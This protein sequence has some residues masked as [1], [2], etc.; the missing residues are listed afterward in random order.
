MI[1]FPNR[2][3]GIIPL[4]THLHTVAT[5][6]SNSLATCFVV[7]YLFVIV[8]LSAIYTRSEFDASGAAC[9]AAALRSLA[10]VGTDYVSTSETVSI[11]VSISLRR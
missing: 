10:G 11:C 6:T 4:R 8:N 1:R 7:M 9:E 5:D 3:A 2:L